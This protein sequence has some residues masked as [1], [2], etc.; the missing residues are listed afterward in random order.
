M[1]AIPSRQSCKGKKGPLV[2]E[3]FVAAPL[4]M[5]VRRQE[6]GSGRERWMLLRTDLKFEKEGIE[7]R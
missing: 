2:W 6:Q 5:S 1:R 4:E 3:E 7:G